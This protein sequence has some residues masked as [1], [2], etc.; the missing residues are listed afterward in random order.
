MHA[1]RNLR[2][3]EKECLCLYVCPT[4]ATDTESG[5]IDFTKCIG[6][7]MCVRS[8]PSN[9]LTLVPDL[10]PAQQPKTK[11]VADGVFK[12]ASDKVE[13]EM[14][15][16]AAKEKAA[17]PVRRQL[18]EAMEMSFRRQAEDLYREAGYML[19]QCPN[20]RRMLEDM[21]KSDDPEFPREAAVRLLEI[22]QKQQR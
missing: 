17:T 12:T 15:C 4:G 3:C 14:L 18:A 20:V 22:L 7:G 21:A 13:A 9:A 1:I 8:C 5:Q 16:R 10:Y 11:E 2:F 19:P 6:C